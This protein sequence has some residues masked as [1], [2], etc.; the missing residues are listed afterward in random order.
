MNRILIVSICIMFVAQFSSDHEEDWSQL[1]FNP[2]HT[3]STPTS[4]SDHLTI[5]WHY[6]LEPKYQL[7]PKPEHIS[8]EF[9]CCHTSPVVVGDRGYLLGFHSLYCWDLRTGKLLYEVPAY[10]FYPYSPAV[11]DGRVYIA[12][13]E[14]LFRCLDAYTGETL[15]EKNLPDIHFASP[16]VDGDTVYVTVSH[17]NPGGLAKDLSACMWGVTDWSTLVAMDTETGEEIWRYTV[18]DDFSPDVRGTGFPI[19]GNETIFF[20]VNHDPYLAFADPKKQGLICLDARTGAFK[21]K[22]SDILPSLYRGGLSPL[23]TAHYN[24]NLYFGLMSRVICADSENLE[25][26]WEHEFVSLW[27]PLCVGNGVVVVCGTTTDCI[28]AETGKELWKIPVSG[29]GMAAMTEN[30]LFVGSDDGNLYRIDITSG[31][32]I[33]TYH[34]GGHVYS[35]VVAQGRILVGTSENR[36]YCLGGF[37]FYD[38]AFISSVAVML[39]IFLVLKRSRR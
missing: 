14:N 11:A 12:S 35:P 31:E 13:H 3:F 19:L 10:A 18:P 32:I 1:G 16:I 29:R 9:L 26:L 20:Y 7:G 38:A 15:W 27:T 8:Y 39:V 28:D 30:E 22:S 36:I 5:V 2:Q 34:L 17:F 21:W 4:V 33:D 24:N 25:L 6:Q 23:W 37:R